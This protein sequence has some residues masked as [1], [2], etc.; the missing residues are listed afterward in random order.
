MLVISRDAP[1]SSTRTSPTCALLLP[2]PTASFALSEL[3]GGA[4]LDS[5]WSQAGARL[6]PGRSPSS[7]MGNGICHM[8]GKRLPQIAPPLAPS[9]GG[10][11]G[12]RLP[13][14][15]MW[16]QVTHSAT[17]EPPA[18]ARRRWPL[19]GSTEHGMAETECG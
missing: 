15:R 1:G 4:R 3:H 19:L 5:G 2:R 7:P 9:L 10:Q 17:G 16:E 12:G 8:H 13:D 11:R 14:G 18:A 6:E